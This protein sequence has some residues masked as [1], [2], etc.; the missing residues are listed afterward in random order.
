MV[1][2]ST[3]SLAGRN[4]DVLSCIANLSNDEVPTPPEFANRMLD[5]TAVA[6]AEANSGADLWKDSTAKFLD[7]F[8]KS[9]V[10]L[11]EIVKRLQEGLAEE[12]PDARARLDHILVNQVYGIA[13]THLTSLI[14]R[15]SVYCS[16]IANGEHSIGSELFTNASGNV[17]FESL[18][19][20]W[21]ED[22]SCKFCGASKTQF[23]RPAGLETHAYA[24]IHTDNIN[25]LIEELFG[26]EM[27][28]DV[29]IGNP[30]YQLESD[31][32]GHQA[33]PI[34]QKFVEQAKALN[35]RLI[36]MV[37]PARWYSGGMG[38][39][40]FRESMLSDD[41]ILSID[42]FPNSNFVFPQTQIKGGVCYFLWSRDKHGP[43]LVMNHDDN[44]NSKPVLRPLR[45]EGAEVFIRYNEALPI[46]KKVVLDAAGGKWA[47]LSLEQGFMRLVGPI[48]QFGLDTKFRGRTKKRK[49]D[50]KVYRNGGVGYVD[51]A[52]IKSSTKLFD[53]WK[54]FIPRAGSGSDAFP[55]SILGKPFIGEPGSISSFT[56]ICIGPFSSELEA[57]NAISYISTRL[58]RMLV[59]LHKSSQG[60]S[61]SVYA[62]VPN[63]DFAE[64]WTD[65]KLY[66]KYGITA[67][68]IGFIERMIRPME[69]AN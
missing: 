40:S 61:S 41:R 56:Y 57:Q 18:E 43:C 65:E 34:Y 64:P 4:P 68:E 29:I 25:A 9:G 19:H 21:S 58:F 51:R 7:P 42:D 24:F 48:G 46:L 6:W 1:E 60:A 22:G 54:V 45:E 49:N 2:T 8:S 52:E 31:G 14:A 44:L 35:P 36:T 13:I 26:E 59:L 20:S 11:R 12:I 30:P 53:T 47:E 37:I 28:F 17:W 10:F 50:L 66:A 15:R 33:R 38:L 69:L 23:D 32:A 55:H 27:Q 5:K 16:K 3:F 63:Q 39:S 62:F 67:D